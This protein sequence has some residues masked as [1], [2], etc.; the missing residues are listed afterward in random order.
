MSTVMALSLLL[1]AHWNL[2]SQCLGLSPKKAAKLI[3][4]EASFAE[5][6]ADFITYHSPWTSAISFDI[7]L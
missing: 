1:F 3:R 7:G 4:S 5:F 2:E 6:T